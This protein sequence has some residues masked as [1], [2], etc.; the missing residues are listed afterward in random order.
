ML[1][2]IDCTPIAYV[3]VTPAAAFFLQMPKF[4]SESRSKDPLLLN[5]RTTNLHSR[6]SNPSHFLQQN[7]SAAV[8]EGARSTASKT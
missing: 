3:T 1:T 5:Q 6:L 8:C 4:R 2:Y 7:L